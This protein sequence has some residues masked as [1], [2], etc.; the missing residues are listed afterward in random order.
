MLFA[1]M[2]P[3]TL[4]RSSWFLPIFSSV[5][6]FSPTLMPSFD[7]GAFSIPGG[8]WTSQRDPIL[9]RQPVTTPPVAINDS[10]AWTIWN[11]HGLTVD[12]STSFPIFVTQPLPHSLTWI[13]R[14]GP[15][16]VNSCLPF[17]WCSFICPAVWRYH[18]AFTSSGR[19]VTLA[20]PSPFPI[21]NSP[22][23]MGRTVPCV[24]PVFDSHQAEAG[25]AEAASTAIMPARMLSVF[26]LKMFFFFSFVFFFVFF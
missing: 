23:L 22:A 8:T 11:S 20:S 24:W 9:S 15:L 6:S 3:F 1:Y 12:A 2:L 4:T 16:V 5:I 21:M 17:F 25:V 13:W 14:C 7:S 10:F 18:I 19:Q 26:S